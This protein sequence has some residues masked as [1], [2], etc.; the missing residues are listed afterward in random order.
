MYPSYDG[1]DE[2]FLNYYYHS[3]LF[4][5]M[6]NASNPHNQEEPMRLPA[7]YNVD[8]AQYYVCTDQLTGF[9]VLHHSLGPV[10][11]W[12]WWAYP[13]FDLNWHWLELR[14]N[15]QPST[16]SHL[17]VLFAIAVS[18][19]LL[20]I[21]TGMRYLNISKPTWLVI[22]KHDSVVFSCLLY[23]SPSP[24]DATLSRMPSSA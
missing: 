22:L 17:G 12:K 3:L 2:G 7:G 11:P 14:D 8:I 19:L 16:N 9:K 13:F 15:L 5:P 18:L 6:F 23:T 1:A 20:A 21:I 10:K 4:A 24:R